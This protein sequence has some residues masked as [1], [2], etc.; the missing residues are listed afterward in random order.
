MSVYATVADETHSDRVVDCTSADGVFLALDGLVV[1]HES[2]AHN[3]GDRAGCS[4]AIVNRW[5]HRLH[6]GM[7]PEAW[8]VLRDM[9]KP[10][11][12]VPGNIRR[13]GV[14]AFLMPEWTEFKVARLVTERR[15]RDVIHRWLDT[16][17]FPTS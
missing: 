13:E 17:E 9:P 5:G 7:H 14:V 11:I 6:V 16:N 15:A 3:V 10:T 2:A 4:A 1:A 8:V 12:R